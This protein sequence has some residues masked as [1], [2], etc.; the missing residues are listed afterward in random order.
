MSKIT[1]S[2]EQMESNAFPDGLY[3]LRLEG[4]E[5]KLSKNG[6]S[7]NLNP[8]VKIVNHP[9]LNN[10]RV[11][12]NMN[13]GAPWII[14]AIIHAFG[15]ELVPNQQGGGD[16]P[17]DFLPE[18]EPDPSKWTYQGPLTGMVAKVL[19]KQTEYNG[20]KSSKVDQWMCALGPKCNTKHPQK[21]AK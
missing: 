14:E 7:I 4:F 13:T 10:K 11:F 1:F 15:L 16:I 20:R 3:E 6:D 2:K 5:P 21:L 9:T 17:G 12:D 18:G 8:V 19:L